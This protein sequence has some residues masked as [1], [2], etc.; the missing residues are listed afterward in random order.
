LAL[1]NF[2]VADLDGIQ[3]REPQLSILQNLAEAFPG[4]WLDCGLRGP[5]DVPDCLASQDVV[6]VAGLES[7]D[8]PGGLSGLCHRLGPE[9]IVFSLDL[10]AGL[11]LGNLERWASRLPLGIAREAIDGGVQNVIVLDLAQV[12]VS[13]GLST[14]PLCRQLKEEFPHIQV[15]TGGG[16]RHVEDLIELKKS[17][18]DG[19]LVASAFHNGNIGRGE[20]HKLGFVPAPLGGEG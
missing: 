4:L 8:G 6:F 9:R 12:G 13:T 2:Y 19:A 10:K 3:Y 20:L 18:I 5:G 11:P 17:R 1:S 7:L 15:V 14:L 16:I